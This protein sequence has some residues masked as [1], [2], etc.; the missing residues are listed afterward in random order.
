[1]GTVFPTLFL[2]GKCVYIKRLLQSENAKIETI[3]P[4]QILKSIKVIQSFLGGGLSVVY[5]RVKGCLSLY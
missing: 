3:T 2:S 5:I 1:M 4:Y